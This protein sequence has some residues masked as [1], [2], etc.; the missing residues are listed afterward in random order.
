MLQ[1]LTLERMSRECVLL[2]SEKVK[3]NEGTG[4]ACF[5][6]NDYIF[7]MNLGTLCM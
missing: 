6:Q 1:H 2:P 5:Y 7:H 4:Y 3:K